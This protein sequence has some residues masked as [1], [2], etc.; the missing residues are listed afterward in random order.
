MRALHNSVVFKREL[1]RK[2]KLL[3]FKPIAVPILIYGHKFWIIT[4]RVRS[5][6]QASEMRFLQKIIGVAMFK[7]VRSTAFGESLK[8]KL[9]LLSIRR[10]YLDSLAM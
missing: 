2:A 6:M 7:N 9:L 1:L 3:V 10:S 4:K 8:I 5:Q